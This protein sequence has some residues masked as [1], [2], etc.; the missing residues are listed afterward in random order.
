[1]S[2]GA[3]KATK[4]LRARLAA[5]RDAL[6]AGDG[7]GARA[8]TREALALDDTS[9]DAWVFDGKAAFACGD[10]RD[11]LAPYAR[12]EDRDDHPAARRAVEAALGF[13]TSSPSPS[14]KPRVLSCTR[15]GTRWRSPRTK[16]LTPAR[17]VAWTAAP[18]RRAGGR[19]PPGA[20]ALD[21]LAV[22]EDSS[23]TR[24]CTIRTIRASLKTWMFS[25]KRV[26]ATAARCPIRAWSFARR[27]R[28]RCA[29]PRK[30][31]RRY[32]ERTA[33]R[34]CAI[35]HHRVASRDRR[36]ARRRRRRAR[37]FPA[38]GAPCARC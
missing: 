12:R 21:G 14:L 8:L 36:P 33:P 24:D 16:Q 23:D 17:R 9:Y 35:V 37:L 28:A 26:Q 19:E 11:A 2:A 5:A 25:P 3:S 15:C 31:L 10:S 13:Q 6:T 29:P 27:G 1:M 4:A 18:R 7:Q 34:G 32:D 38:S 30:R 22:K 20:R